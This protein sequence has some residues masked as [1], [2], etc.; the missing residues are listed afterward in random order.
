MP[1]A[2][3]VL[4]GGV[5]FANAVRR[6]LLADVVGAA[7][8]EVTVRAN[9]SCLADEYLAHRLGLVPMRRV[10]AGDAMELDATGPAVVLAR[11][12]TSPAYEPVHGDIELAVLGEGERLRLSVRVDERPARA[13]ARYAACAAVGLRPLDAEHSELAFETVDERDPRAALLEALGHLDARC[14]RAL[15]A[16]AHQPAEPPRSFC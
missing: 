16:L 6:T 8:C 10:G 3:F 15:Q 2:A 4:S 5:G 11:D 14:E 1:R 12:L 13:H 9:T 7:P